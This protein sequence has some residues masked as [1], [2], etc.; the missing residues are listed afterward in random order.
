M[1][2]TPVGSESSRWV[3]VDLS[4]ASARLSRTGGV[5]TASAAQCDR[6]FSPGPGDCTSPD[7]T[8]D[9]CRI[10]CNRICG[11]AGSRRIILLYTAFRAIHPCCRVSISW[12]FRSQS[13][14]RRFSEL[15]LCE[16]KRFWLPPDRFRHSATLRRRLTRQHDR[17]PID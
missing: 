17:K 9:C 12:C 14:T 15:V 2:W 11:I 3:R 6:A 5:L 8:A 13:G 1:P 10:R 4:D 16:L 7:R